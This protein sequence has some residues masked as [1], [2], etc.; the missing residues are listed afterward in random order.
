MIR[1]I[2]KNKKI[3]LPSRLKRALIYLRQKQLA[4]RDWKQRYSRVFSNTPRLRAKVDGDLENAHKKYWSF[5][6]RNVELDT[7]R[8]C[9]NISGNAVPEIVP[10]NIFV[11]DIQHSL[12]HYLDVSFLTNKSFYHKWHNPDFFPDNI[13]HNIDGELVDNNLNTI[14]LSQ[15]ERLV[16]G[17]DFPVLTKPNIDSG[18]GKNIRIV[19]TKQEL[20]EFTQNDKNYVVQKILNQSDFFRA[21]NPDSI[22][23]IRVCLYR[24][25]NDNQIHILNTVLRTGCGATHVDNEAAGGIVCFVNEDGQ[26]NGYAVDKY[27]NK[28]S[29]HPNSGVPFVGAIPQFER[30]KQIAKEVAHQTF[31]ARLTSLDMC[32]DSNKR[33]RVI[34]VNLYGHS[35]RFPQ[36]AGHPFFGPF[37]EEVIE[38]CKDHHWALG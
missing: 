8:V 36:Y 6:R 12:N 16:D 4:N 24:S 20:L 10:E 21:F 14:G 7:L 22:N 3:S 35:I 27:G 34:E 2:L 23:T 29:H 5:F 33:W 15:V 13:F 1:R 11:A 37:T 25:V 32:F 26:L 38:Y 31:L 18:G 30:M 9:K 28:Y 19:K 17:L